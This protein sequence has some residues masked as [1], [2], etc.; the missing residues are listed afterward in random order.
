[1]ESLP[2]EEL[3]ARIDGIPPL[4]EVAQ[5]LLQMTESNEFSAQE[6]GE[7]VARDATISAQ[8]LSIANSPLYAPTVDVTEIPRAVMLMGNTAVLNL[9]LGICAAISL[10]PQTLSDRVHEFLWSHSI[11]IASLAVE[12]NGLCGQQ[13]AEELFTAGMFGDIGFITVSTLLPDGRGHRLFSQLAHPELEPREAGEFIQ[14]CEGVGV[15]VLE[16]WGIPER[17]RRLVEPEIGGVVTGQNEEEATSRAVLALARDLVEC[18]G[19]WLYAPSLAPMRAARTAT[20]LGLS[21]SDLLQALRSMRGSFDAIAKSLDC[22][23]ILRHPVLTQE[24]EPILIVGEEPEDD[25]DLLAVLLEDCGFGYERIRAE[26]FEQQELLGRYVM[27]QAQV[28][29]CSQQIDQARA[30]LAIGAAG[31]G[32]MGLAELAMPMDVPEGR[33][34]MF[35][36]PRVPRISDLHRAR[37]VSRAPVREGSLRDVLQKHLTCK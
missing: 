19:W 18:K 10:R 17:L 25:V 5:Q 32:M 27:I 15:R 2:I 22:E 9:V 6:I 26:D 11:A 36:M 4:P 30:A 23:G 3:I 31:I 7:V 24:L 37:I 21:E 12:L 16:S 13:N 35:A 34:R 28:R 33:G 14:E 8:I 1:L 29:G 20:W